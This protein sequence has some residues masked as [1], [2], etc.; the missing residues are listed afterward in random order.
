MS[1]IETCRHRLLFIKEVWSLEVLR[2]FV[3][4]VKICLTRPGYV[5][6]TDMAALG[7]G[8][9]SYTYGRLQFN[10]T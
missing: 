5:V 10:E 9:A 1:G 4:S 3:G 8:K 6:N 7:R 2:Y